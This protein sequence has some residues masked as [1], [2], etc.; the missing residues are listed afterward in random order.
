MGGD[1]WCKLLCLFE[2]GFGFRS[3]KLWKFSLF[4][5]LGDFNVVWSVF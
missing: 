5:K 4:F 2:N 3:G 1:C